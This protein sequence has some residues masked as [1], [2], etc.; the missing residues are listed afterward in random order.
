MKPHSISCIDGLKGSMENQ[1]DI[2]VEG[3]VKFLKTSTTRNGKTLQKFLLTD[4]NESSRVISFF[5]DSSEDLLEV[6]LFNSCTIYNPF[7]RK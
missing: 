2:P 6:I 7:S 4:Q 3:K 1:K 5:P